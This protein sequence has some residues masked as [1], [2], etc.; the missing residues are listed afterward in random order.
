MKAMDAKKT[1][2][3]AA[4][5]TGQTMLE[6]LVASAVVLVGAGIV[7]ALMH[8]GARSG[9]VTRDAAHLLAALDRVE[10][11][12]RR[13]LRRAVGG[14]RGVTLAS[15]AEGIDVV[16]VDERTRALR[17]VPWRLAPDGTIFR[18]GTKFATL[19]LKFTGFQFRIDRSLVPGEPDRLALDLRAE[20]P[21]VHPG[22]G[23]P[24]TVRISIRKWLEE[25][26]VR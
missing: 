19:T 13:D 17:V 6:V 24:R 15:G 23:S 14:P 9:S 2:G 25:S 4:R 8:S 18:D 26:A 1:L 5:P 12:L 11:A 21:K 7:A 20:W 22:A 3:R 10:T 16:V